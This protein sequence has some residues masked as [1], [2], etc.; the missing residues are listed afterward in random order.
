MLKQ[1]IFI[2]ISMLVGVAYSQNWS[3]LNDTG[4][5]SLDGTVYALAITQST[6]DLYVGGLCYLLICFFLIS[7]VI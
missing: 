6:G 3:A 1:A 5:S 2:L 4:S 7:D